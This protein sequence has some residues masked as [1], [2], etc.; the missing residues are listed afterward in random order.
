MASKTVRWFQDVYSTS[1]REF[2][3]ELFTW[4]QECP[5][6]LFHYTSTQGLLGILQY[7]ALWATERRFLNDSSEVVY[8]TDLLKSICSEQLDKERCA[9]ARQV[10]DLFLKAEAGQPERSF[11][12]CF[13][14]DGNLLNQWRVYAGQGGYSLEFGTAGFVIDPRS[15]DV[16]SPARVLLPVVYDP[17]TQQSLLRRRVVA[18]CNAICEVA[19]GAQGNESNELIE[20]G[21]RA[22]LSS[23]NRLLSQ[24]KDPAFKVE[25]EW[26]LLNCDEN[27]DRFIQFRAGAYGL[28][29]YISFDISVE[30]TTGNTL[31]LRSI[32]LGPTRHAENSEWAIRELL[33]KYD[34]PE[35]QVKHSRLPV[36]I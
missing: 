15:K 16:P 30:G 19:P 25:S 22:L 27:A 17:D 32:T 24:F 36:R 11:I 34:Y 7:K 6:S 28:T 21:L 35:V 20:K 4:Q 2:E 29:P 33:R 12:S 9:E 14:D 18:I 23:T 8:G 31:P 3:K 5:K 26:R 1:F 13:C 10:L